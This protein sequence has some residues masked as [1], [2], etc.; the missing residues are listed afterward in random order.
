MTAV[1]MTEVKKFDLAEIRDLDL[2]E[3]E[4]VDGG[5]YRVFNVI[6]IISGIEWAANKAYEAGVWVGSH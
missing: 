1:T 3:I 2:S 4:L 5:R 6:S